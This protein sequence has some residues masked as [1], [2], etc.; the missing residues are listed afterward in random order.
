MIKNNIKKISVFILKIFIGL[1]ARVANAS[2][3][4]KCLHKNVYP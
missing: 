3:H 1:L 2:T 4:T